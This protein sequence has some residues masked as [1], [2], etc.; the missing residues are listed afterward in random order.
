MPVVS[1]G[2]R[3]AYS[4]KVG[5]PRFSKALASALD[6][7]NRCFSRQLWE[8]CSAPAARL[9]ASSGI[10]LSRSFLRHRERPW[11][12]PDGFSPGFPW[13]GKSASRAVQ[14]RRLSGCT[15]TPCPET[16]GI[17]SG[18]GDTWSQPC[19]AASVTDAMPGEPSTRKLA[20]TGTPNRTM[21]MNSRKM[22]GHGDCKMDV[23]REPTMR[24]RQG[25]RN[26]IVESPNGFQA[27]GQWP[28]KRNPAEVWLKVLRGALFGAQLSWDSR[29][30]E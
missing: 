29:F 3:V 5:W 4:E 12:V 6:R 1:V 19:L 17:G 18:R 22:T 20:R 27:V 10:A 28:S 9:A 16:T 2:S 23:F 8:G 13:Q 14:G 25:A 11:G 21:G 7:P 24:K 15:D 26:R 30:L